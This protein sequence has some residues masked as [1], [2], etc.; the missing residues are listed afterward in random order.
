MCFSRGPLRF[1]RVVKPIVPRALNALPFRFLLIVVNRRSIMISADNLN[2][3]FA[4]RSCLRH[5]CQIIL[6]TDRQINPL[7]A[8][9]CDWDIHVV[10]GRVG[11]GGPIRLPFA[12]AWRAVQHCVLH[13]IA[14]I[15]I[16]EL[17]ITQV[18]QDN[19]YLRIVEFRKGLGI[20]LRIK[21]RI[22]RRAP[23][24]CVVEVIKTLNE[25]LALGFTVVIRV[26][27][28]RDAHRI[29]MIPDLDRF[30]PVFFKTCRCHPVD[31]RYINHAT[32]DLIVAN[33]NLGI[34]CLGR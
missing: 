7:V 11:R 27:I 16:V 3:Q 13:Q 17:L 18:T 30:K 6:G 29:V 5:A 31:N 21:P 12:C 24:E 19:L 34:D 26:L 8:Q 15:K 22:A 32:H 1:V 10:H 2:R 23:I 9:T 33:D 20:A 28:Q 4:H 14:R 25:I